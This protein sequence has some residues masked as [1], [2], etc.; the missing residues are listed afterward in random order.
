VHGVIQFDKRF[1]MV[2]SLVARALHGA[3]MMI[4][5]GS[6]DFKPL[7]YFR[8]LPRRQ[9]RRTSRCISQASAFEDANRPIALQTGSPT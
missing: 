9:I 7:H 5:Y 1:C 3:F 2:G 4:M 6:S 8:Y